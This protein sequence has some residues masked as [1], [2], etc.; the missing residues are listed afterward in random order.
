MEVF[1]HSVSSSLPTSDTHRGCHDNGYV[2]TLRS[3]ITAGYKHKLILLRSYSEMAAGINEL[4]LPC[5]GIPDL[6][7]PQKLVVPLNLTHNNLISAQSHPTP[8]PT[9]SASLER[10]I[11]HRASFSGIQQGFEALPFA[12]SELDETVKQRPSPP[13]YSSA[14]QGPPRRTATPELD[15][16]GS[17]S[18][19]D[20]SD[21][22]SPDIRQISL[23]N[24]RSRRVNP[25]I[26]S[27]NI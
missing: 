14:L 22:G 15:S 23:T 25:N 16:S 10:P 21:E 4:E 11:G 12:T 3:Q 5:F 9:N 6:F 27:I 17:T 20:E 1:G 19:S 7:I 18:S 13:S 24:L 2:N 26:V 8:P